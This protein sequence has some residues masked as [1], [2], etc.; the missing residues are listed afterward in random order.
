MYIED[1]SKLFNFI[2]IFEYNLLILQYLDLL[3]FYIY[4][5]IGL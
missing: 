1:C 4:N 5:D 3:M 2:F